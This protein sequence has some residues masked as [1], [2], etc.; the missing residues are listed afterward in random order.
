MSLTAGTRFGSYE[1]TAPL[2]AGGMGEVY[3]AVRRT[4]SLWYA[5]CVFAIDRREE[6]RWQIKLSASY[7]R[8]SETRG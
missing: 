1:I 6:S 3:R 5:I 4:E 2:A 7:R 8:G